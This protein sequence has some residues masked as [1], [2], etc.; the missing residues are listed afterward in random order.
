MAIERFNFG[1]IIKFKTRFEDLNDDGITDASGVIFL[2]RESGVKEYWNGTSFQVARVS[3]VML[4]VGEVNHA[5]VWE[6][7]FDTSVG[8]AID[9]YVAEFRDT[10]G[11]S[12]NK[13]EILNALVGGYLDP[14]V[15]D[16]QRLLGLNHE[17]FV[18]EPT[19]FAT[20]SGIMTVGD[21]YLYDTKANADA[22]GRSIAT[23]LI[24]K[25]HVEA[26][27]SP[28]TGFL[29]KFTQTQETIS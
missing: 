5:G 8:L 26:P 18:T 19:A 14:L 15:T 11:N 24:A 2:Y 28:S 7:S 25:Y 16:I 27:R 29:I 23:G 3:V 13:I 17:N 9:E 12:V 4:E 6:F 20:P 10:S 21:V 22:D 1:D